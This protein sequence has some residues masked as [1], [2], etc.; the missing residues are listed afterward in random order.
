ME[1]KQLISYCRSFREGLLGGRS[2]YLM[3]AA[4]CWPLVGLLEMLYSV[5]C[6]AVESHLGEINHV[7]IK[8]ADGRALDPTADQFNGILCTAA[9]RLLGCGSNKLPD[10]YLGKPLMI[11]ATDNSMKLFKLRSMV[12]QV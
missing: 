10:V 2:S 7:W 5:K 4:V 8:L 1:D 11:H 9:I 6:E 12:A 3:C